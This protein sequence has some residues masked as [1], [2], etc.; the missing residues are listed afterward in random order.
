MTITV[1]VR[2]KAKEKNA[3]LTETS[4]AIYKNKEVVFNVRKYPHFYLH[5]QS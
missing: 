1:L 3:C 4:D 2:R 5:S